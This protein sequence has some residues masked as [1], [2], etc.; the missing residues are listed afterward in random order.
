MSPQ[1]VEALRGAWPRM[2]I[3][4]IDAP[5]SGGPARARDGTMSLM[6][7]LPMP[8]SNAAARCIDALSTKVFRISQRPAT[9]RAPSWSTTCWPASTWWARPK[10]WPWP[11][12]AWAWIWG[13][14]DWM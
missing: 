3:D 11:H 14:H 7:A 12:R 13:R 8:C 9:A 2:G 6:V 4:T 1:D 5:M 10:C